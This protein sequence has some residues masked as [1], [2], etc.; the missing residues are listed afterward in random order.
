MK[1]IFL[2]LCI[3]VYLQI[4]FA[5][6]AITTDNSAPDGT[7]MLD[8][9]STSKGVLVPRMTATQRD[10]IVSPA[11]GLLIFCT[12]D[13]QYYSFQAAGAGGNWMV[14]N[15]QWAASG[16]NINFPIGNVGI[17]TWAPGSKLTVAGFIESNYGGF[18]FPDGTYQYSASGALPSGTSGQTLRHDGTSWLS[19]ST[20]INDG[21]KIGLGM[22][23]TSSTARLQIACDPSNYSGIGFYYSGVNSGEIRPNNGNLYLDA[24]KSTTEIPGNLILQR[25]S[26]VGLPISYA[27]DVLIGT[28][29][30]PLAKLHVEGFEGNTVALFRRY[31]TSPGISIVSDWPGIYGNCYFNGGPKTM[32]ASG[33]S[34]VINFN[35]DDGSID[36]LTHSTPNTAANASITMAESMRIG[37]D[38]RVAIGTSYPA[39]GYKLSV[40]GKVIC[41]EV[42]VKYQAYWPDYVFNKDYKLSP[43]S[44][45][46][47]YIVKNNHLPNMPDAAEIQKNGIPIGEMQK[48]MMEKIEELTLYIIAQDKKINALESKLNSKK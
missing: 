9:K 19:S 22:T 34:A 44:D 42:N 4:G 32:T 45:V 11:N 17:G 10:A 48:K 21:S 29:G 39:T 47:N 3:S 35:Q 40:A 25:T 8:V 7:S 38:G 18:K 43:L 37:S 28:S 30:P 24:K 15:T 16:A 20:L 31:D 2:L 6:V 23:P 27:G 33:Y 13:N 26:Y 14:V 5:Q 36:F 46:E 1:K 41:E 12:G